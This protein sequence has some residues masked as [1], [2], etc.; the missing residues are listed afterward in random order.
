MKEVMQYQ[1]ASMQDVAGR[2][3]KQLK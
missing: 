1:H 2:R 3:N